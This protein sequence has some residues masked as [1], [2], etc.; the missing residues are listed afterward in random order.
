MSLNEFLAFCILGVAFMMYAL[1]QWTCGDKHSAH[2]RQLPAR[3]DTL[4]NQSG[5][6]FLVS[7]KNLLMDPEDHPEASVCRL[8]ESRPRTI[9]S[10]WSSDG[11]ALESRLGSCP[12]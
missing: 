10:D 8:L 5:R 7:R 11:S 9:G 12:I 6:P 2:G 1:L 3:K 4:V